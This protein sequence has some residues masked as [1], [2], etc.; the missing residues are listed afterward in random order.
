V[1]YSKQNKEK[2]SSMKRSHTYMVDFGWSQ[3]IKP[4]ELRGPNIV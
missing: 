1:I 4:C 2:L 3:A